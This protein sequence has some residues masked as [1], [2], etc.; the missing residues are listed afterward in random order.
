MSQSGESSQPA[1]D[2]EKAI[3]EYLE[4]IDQG[5]AFDVEDWLARYGSIRSELQEFLDT[6]RE[7]DAAFPSKP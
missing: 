7:F 1:D 6:E 4:R 5:A 3:A 2:L